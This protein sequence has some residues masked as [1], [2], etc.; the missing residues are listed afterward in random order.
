M[1]LFSIGW[2]VE[3]GVEIFPLPEASDNDR[4]VAESLLNNAVIAAKGILPGCQDTGTA[5]Q[6]G[7]DIHCLF[8]LVGASAPPDLPNKSPWRLQTKLVVKLVKFAMTAL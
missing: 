4:F 8:S 3:V 1:F 2:G 7:S 5:T 6:F